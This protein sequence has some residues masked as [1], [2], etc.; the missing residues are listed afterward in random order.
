MQTND[1]QRD[2]EYETVR[3]SGGVNKGEN[4]PVE[5]KWRG[6]DGSGI[7]KRH[8]RRDEAGYW[9]LAEGCV[10]RNRGNCWCYH[11]ARLEAKNGG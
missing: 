11:L 4:V 2:N 10:R 6:V 9:W 7:G 8:G 3:V 5:K 1:E